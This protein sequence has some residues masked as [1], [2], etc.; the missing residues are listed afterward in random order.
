MITVKY[1]S[2]CLKIEGHAG[3][4]KYGED[5]VCAAVSSLWHTWKRKMKKEAEKGKLS[6]SCQEFPGNAC[7]A[8]TWVKNEYQIAFDEIMDTVQMGIRLLAADY[9]E[10]VSAEKF[11]GVD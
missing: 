10:Y 2:R 8:V 7:L 11:Q 5:I 9:P 6:F 3:Y 4:G 1:N